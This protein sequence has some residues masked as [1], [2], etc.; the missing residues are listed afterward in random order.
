[1]AEPGPHTSQAL[2]SEE[3]VAFWRTQTLLSWSWP[4]CH[5]L[6][7]PYS[8]DAKTGNHNSQ[9]DNPHLKRKKMKQ[10]TIFLSFSCFSKT[11][12]FVPANK[13]PLLK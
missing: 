9:K 12:F 13:T 4:W 8:Q 11:Y 7:V 3:T 1:M 5:Q 10:D 6:Q 2:N